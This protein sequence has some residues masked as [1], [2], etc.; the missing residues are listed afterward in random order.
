MLTLE[1]PIDSDWALLHG[2]SEEEVSQ[3]FREILAAKLFEMR[4]LTL[5]QASR[6][7]GLPQW[8][9]MER[10]AQ[11]GVSTANLTEDQAK[12]DITSA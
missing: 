8:K 6:M 10:L 2:R 4:R 7:T 1:I 12:D 11:L 5:G 3:E 9:F